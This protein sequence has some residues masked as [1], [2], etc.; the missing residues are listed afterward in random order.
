MEMK[1]VLLFYFLLNYG[2]LC[3]VIGYYMGKRDRA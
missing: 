3:V 1:Q 2:F